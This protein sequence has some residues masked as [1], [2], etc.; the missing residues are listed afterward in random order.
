MSDIEP[1]GWRQP[2]D[3]TWETVDEDGWTTDSDPDDTLPHRIQERRRN[4]LRV[5]G[6]QSMP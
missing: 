2:A 4:R 1:A 3:G 6:Q 5:V